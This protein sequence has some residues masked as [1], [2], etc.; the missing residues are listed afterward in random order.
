MAGKSSRKAEQVKPRRRTRRA[1]QP[2]AA[3]PA[4]AQPDAG[5]LARHQAILDSTLDPIVTIDAFGM[6]L[7][8]SRSVQR[9]LGYAPEEMVG[10]NISL[11]M[12]APHR[13][14]HDGYLANYRRTGITNILGRSREFEAV[15]KD[16]SAFTVEISVSRV[17]VPGESQPL[18]T[19]IIHDISQRR[20]AEEELRLLQE[21]SLAIGEATDLNSALETTLQR[22]CQATGWEYG[23]AWLPDPSA[24]ALLGSPVWHSSEPTFERFR[25]RTHSLRFERGVGLPGRVWTSRRSEWVDDL[26]SDGTFQRVEAAAEAGLHAAL[27]VP[28]LY[29]SEVAAVIAFFMKKRRPIDARLLTLVTT[30][31]APLGSAIMR[32]R[33]QDVLAESERRFR[34]LLQRVQLVGVILDRSGSITFC[35]DCFLNLTQWA[36]SEVIGRNWFDLCL[37]RAERARTFEVFHQAIMSGVIEPHFEN[38]IVTRAG[39]ERL[40]AW[41]NSIMCDEQGRT[42]AVAGLGVDITDQRRIEHELKQHRENLEHLVAERTS[43]LRRTIEQLRMADRLASIG[44]LAAGLGHDMNNVLLPMRCRLDAA[45][46][47]DL[48]PAARQELEIVRRLADYLQQLSDGL[49]LLALD[50]DDS[51]ASQPTTHIEQWWQQ[52]SVLLHK[53]VPKHAR[54]EAELPAGLPDLPV[55]PHRL[56]QAVLNLVVNAGEAIGEG[57]FVRFWAQGDP[58]GVSIRLGVTDNGCGISE[59]VQHRIFDPFFTTKPR[60]LGTGM[61]LSLV[62]GV[63]QAAGGR[64]FVES[65]VGIGTTI[66]MEL[67]IAEPPQ[68]PEPQ[69]TA[70]LAM[71]DVRLRTLVETMLRV[72]GFEVQVKPGGEET[73]A[74][75]WF[76]DSHDDRLDAARRFLRERGE[77]QIILCGPAGEAWSSMDVF[78]INDVNDF[79]EVRRV[80][81]EAIDAYEGVLE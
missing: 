17:D 13:E 26:S 65:Q 71:S 56:T 35:N 5:L 25:A 16:G 49:H 33:M 19:G 53:A 52:V 41:N 68:A 18:F 55:A 32:K 7:S 64:V 59:E 1:A 46:S 61:G 75:L 77:R 29:E 38:R 62:R 80:I 2:G 8:A 39:E 31:V 73:D 12:P 76:I 66:G 45:E 21:L 47:L 10:R 6:V 44:T 63:A 69:R 23:E 81:R 37:P 36:R 40:I 28:I 58:A 20:R 42:V 3:R 14:K 34:D 50:P 72:E 79:D 54:F 67:P 11:I 60:G 24:P 57:G 74:S 78:C 9:V 27:A 43:E 70:S 4:S 48:P 51:E 22:I 30:A 15:R